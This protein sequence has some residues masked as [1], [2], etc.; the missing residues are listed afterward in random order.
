MNKRS[1][2]GLVLIIVGALAMAYQGF[3]YTTRKKTVDIGSIQITKKEHHRVWVPP[4]LG[5]LV[6]VG[7]I[8]LLVTDRHGQ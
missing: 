5:A 3:T 8:V 7:G 4:L 2:W 6:L 1:F